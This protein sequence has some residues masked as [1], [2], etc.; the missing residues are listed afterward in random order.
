MPFDAN[1]YAATAKQLKESGL[2]DDLIRY[3]LQSAFP[4][5]GD[6]GEWWQ[7]AL[8][9]A[10]EQNTPQAMR[11]KLKVQNEFDR[12]RMKAAAPYKLLFDIPGQITQAFTLPGQ[13]AME[14]AN[15]ISNTVMEGVRALPGPQIVARSAQYT[16][17]SY[18]GRG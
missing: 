6:N 11:E 9:F 17:T 4:A 1:A 12:E 2:S 18:F 8:N 13:L 16:P 14:G 5:G 7:K 3:G 15:R 10:Q